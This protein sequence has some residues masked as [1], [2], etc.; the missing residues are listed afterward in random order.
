GAV[1]VG[2]GLNVSLRA[3]ELP[4]PTATSLVIEEA[5]CAD[6]DPLIR[7]VLREIETHY[8]EWSQA[9]GDADACGLRAAYLGLSATVGREVRVELPG[10]RMLTGL[11]TGVDAAGHLLV[12]SQGSV[13]TLSAG[14][15]V[16][17]RPHTP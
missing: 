5:A 7:A 11:A 3:E 4:V 15:V 8:D 10:E 14:D 17:V 6:R 16:H 1:V 13:H 12:E 9:D 2:V